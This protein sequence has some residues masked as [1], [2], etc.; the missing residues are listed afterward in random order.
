MPGRVLENSTCNQ[1]E[2]AEAVVSKERRSSTDSEIQV[3][4]LFVMPREIRDMIVGSLSKKE[5]KPLSIMEVSVP[6]LS[7]S[8]LFRLSN[9]SPHDTPK[10]RIYFYLPLQYDT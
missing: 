3:L 9:L 4:P 10:T 8:S 7:L 5:K 1:L 2:T 6:R